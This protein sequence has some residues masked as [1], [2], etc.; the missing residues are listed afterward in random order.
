MAVVTSAGSAAVLASDAGRLHAF[1]EKA[2][3]IDDKNRIIIAKM[4][5]DAVTQVITPIGG[6]PRRAIQKLLKAVGCR[7]ANCFSELPAVLALH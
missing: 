1:L 3:C 6:V 7:I 5:D 4:V 2:C